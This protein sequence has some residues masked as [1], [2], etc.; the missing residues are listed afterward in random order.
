M[1]CYP[2]GRITRWVHYRHKRMD[3]VSTSKLFK[4]YLVCTQRPKVIQENILCKPFSVN[5]RDG[6][7]LEMREHP[8]ISALSEILRPGC[9][10]SLNFY[11]VI[12]GIW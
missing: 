5:T 8:S 7:T 10:K 3:M 4:K 6:L 9:S 11:M 1:V 12:P 2:A